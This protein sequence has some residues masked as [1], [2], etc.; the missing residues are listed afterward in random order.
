MG[1]L[2]GL[3]VSFAYVF[4]FI[5]IATYF[6]ARGWLQPYA[7]RK[8]VHIGVAHWWL[9]YLAFI[10]DPLVGLAG[11]GSFIIIN[12]LSF[13]LHLFKAMED[14]EPRKNLGTVYFPISLVVLIL[15]TMAG[16]LNVYEAGVGVMI[17][18]W[19]DGMAALVGRRFGKTSV[20]IFGQTKSVAGTFALIMFS[21]GATAGMSLLADPGIDPWT[22]ILRAGA[23]GFFAA[24]VELCTPFGLDNLS[25]P[26]LGA[27]FYRFVASGPLAGPF[28]AAAAF[29]A[30][31]AYGAFRKQAVS[32]SGAAIGAAVGTAI[33]VAGGFA[34]YS[35]LIGFFLSSTAIGRM[36]GSKKK[37][38]GIEEKGDRRDAIQVLANAGAGAL[39]SIMYAGTG[40]LFWL[41]AFAASF[42]SA[43]ADTWA[44]EIGVLYRKAPRSILTL[45]PVPAGTSGG[46]SP[47]GFLASALGA[48][49]IGLLFAV[50]YGTVDG[51]P[52]GI[53]TIALVAT[54]GGFFGAFVDSVLGATIQ[55]H[56]TCAKTGRSTERPHT[57][58]VPNILVSGLRWFNNDM[59]NLFSTI[60]SSLGS[61]AL[62][63]LLRSVA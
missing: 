37:P 52:E 7:T 61:A 40:E 18:G 33:L 32:A 46:V 53:G 56:Y 3:L 6:R 10:R 15:F 45:K 31:V 30:I 59:V 36:L 27:L 60:I 14:P 13:R 55:A 35:L 11:A 50:A 20:R 17:M 51:K 43:N 16:W 24:L 4:A 62:F 58:G 29:N 48:S 38:S 28:A 23:T 49:F 34:A 57:D 19:G 8:V 1:S 12:F 9:L 54:L 41:A 42:A 47:L 44:S 26:I 22:L 25:L 5:G 63:L 21:A 2:A 39:A